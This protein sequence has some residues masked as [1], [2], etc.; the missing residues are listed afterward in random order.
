MRFSTIIPALFA[1]STFAAP[2]IPV[3]VPVTRDLVLAPRAVSDIEASAKAVMDSKVADGCEVVKCLIALAP[4]AV[5]CAAAL[6]EA[7]VNVL[8]DAACFAT[9]LNSAANPPAACTSCAD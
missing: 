5:S 1:A 2:R 8:A 4:T 9:A 3:D 6:A 7:G